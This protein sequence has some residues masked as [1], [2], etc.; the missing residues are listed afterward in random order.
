MT[1][2]IPVTQVSAA[3]RIQADHVYVVPPNRRL[4]VVDGMINVHEITQT[5]QR[6]SP[7]DVFFRALADAHGSRA[8]CIVLSG[9]GSNGSAGLKRVKEY[10]GLAIAQTPAEAAYADMPTNAIATGMVDLVLPVAEM[11][12]RIADYHQRLRQFDGGSPE[13]AEPVDDSDA[14]TRRAVA[15]ARAH[16]P[17]LRQLQGRHAPAPHPAADERRRRLEPRRLRT[18]HTR[19]ARGSGRADEGP[20]DQRHPL[21]P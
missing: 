12:A 2:D 20:A 11:P 14:L 8:V 9:T 17:R 6:R 15:A 21:L 13:D 4:E 3:V 7:V 19:A 18:A 1:S 10:G 5:E 16:R